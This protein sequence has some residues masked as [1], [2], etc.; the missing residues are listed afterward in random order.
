MYTI[1]A[2]S[3]MTNTSI[4]TLR[5]YDSLKLL[6]PSLKGEF[7]N[8]RYYG[9]E[10]LLKLKIIKKLKKMDFS[11]NDISKLLNKYDEKYLLEQKNKLKNNMDNESKS[12]K[13][14]EEIIIKLKDK[15]LDLSNELGSLINKEERRKL[16]MPEKYNNA[17]EK[18]MNCFKLY[19]ESNFQD[20]VILLEELKKDI[21]YSTGEVDEYW[22]NSAGDLFTGIAFEIIKRN[23]PEDVTFFNIFEF[24]IEDKEYIDN[25]TE[26]VDKLEKDSY[27]YIS[28]SIVS[29]T[30]QD[31]KNSII[32]VFKTQLKLYAVL[33]VKK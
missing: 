18:L 25:I 26:Y 5:Y 29:S 14:I 21:F 28:L 20:C 15:N 1:S 17:K 23:K 16:D 33:D 8:Y 9:K 11:L 30:P 3:K 32:S 6:T 13:L 12:I 7:N 24:K 2:F 27:S 31:T 4:Q 10:E 19:K 22:S